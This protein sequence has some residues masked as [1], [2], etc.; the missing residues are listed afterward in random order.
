MNSTAVEWDPEE[1]AQI[2]IEGFNIGVKKMLLRILIDSK[3]CPV[4]FY[5]F[6]KVLIDFFKQN[7]DHSFLVFYIHTFK[8]NNPI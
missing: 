8:Y 7:L 4:F 2:S 5:N 3:H 6:A 1:I